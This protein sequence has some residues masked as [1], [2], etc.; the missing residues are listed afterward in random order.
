MSVGEIIAIAGLLI[1]IGTF[2][3]RVA[4]L[5][6]RIQKNEDA[7]KAAHVRIDKFT[8]KYEGS[9]KNIEH[10]ILTLIQVQTRIEEKLSFIIEGKIKVKAIND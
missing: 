8:D 6:T 10:Q 7:N 9:I 3:W 4:V 2:I 5:T 1:T